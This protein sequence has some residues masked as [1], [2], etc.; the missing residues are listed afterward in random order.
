M[1]APSQHPTDL[2]HFIPRIWVFVRPAR[3]ADLPDH[4]LMPESLYA[5]RLPRKRDRETPFREESVAPVSID[6]AGSSTIPFPAGREPPGILE[7]PPK[8]LHAVA[9]RRADA[10]DRLLLSAPREKGAPSPLSISSPSLS[11]SPLCNAI[12]SQA[13]RTLLR[14][15]LRRSLFLSLVALR[16][17]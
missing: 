9:V 4:S 5:S 11:L 13:L 1:I 12:L 8:Q 16:P 2:F 3:P 17:R 7:N 15:F 6:R 10:S 14:R